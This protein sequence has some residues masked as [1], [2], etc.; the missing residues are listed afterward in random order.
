MKSP[1]FTRSLAGLLV[2]P[3]HSDMGLVGCYAQDPK[4]WSHWRVLHRHS[5]IHGAE[6]DFVAEQAYANKST[7]IGVYCLTACR[8]YRYMGRSGARCFCSNDMPTR[9]TAAGESCRV[10]TDGFQSGV[11]M[12]SLAVYVY[13]CGVLW[14]DA[15]G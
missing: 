5:F 9:G 11:S 14:G 13:G 12:Q 1:T 2:T 3:E 8:S 10:Q 4:G 6:L 7:T 15:G